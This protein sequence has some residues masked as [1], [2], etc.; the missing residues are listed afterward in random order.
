[1][2][3]KKKKEDDRKREEQKR[4][5]EER[6]READRQQLEE[7]KQSEGQV[8]DE[9]KRKERLDAER[10]QL[11]K[12]LR[13]QPKY[14]EEDE[15]LVVNLPALESSPMRSHSPA[16]TP[17]HTPSSA[18]QTNTGSKQRL[19]SNSRKADTDRVAQSPPLTFTT[20]EEAVLQIPSLASFTKAEEDYDV[21]ISL[22]ST[23]E[24]QR[25][26]SAKLAELRGKLSM[27][28]HGYIKP[29]TGSVSTKTF[30]QKKD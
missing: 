18:G 4:Q 17:S 5:Q 28:D 13:Y 7:Q 10:M 29:K 25:Q 6:R 22:L 27:S 16:R 19:T 30:W 11:R 21:P 20:K 23:L 9:Q 1:L 8:S 2:K 15:Q 14:Q 12:Q 24:E 3:N 26:S